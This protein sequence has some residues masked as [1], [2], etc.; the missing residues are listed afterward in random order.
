MVGIVFRTPK[1]VS[2]E[3]VHRPT[4]IIALGG[5]YAGRTSTAVPAPGALALLGAAGLV[6][7]R[8]RRA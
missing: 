1:W 5:N 6:G 3:I 2:Q 8:R 4:A 7:A